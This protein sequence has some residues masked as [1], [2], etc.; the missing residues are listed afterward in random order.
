CRQYDAKQAL[1]MGLINHVVPVDELETET[2]KWCREMLEHSPLALRC[3]KAA[4]NADCD[5]QMGLIDLAGD[6]TLLYYMSDEAKEGRQAY[7][8][9]RKPDFSKFPRLP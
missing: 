2:L 5:G 7:V 6:A 9:K 3:L 1:D 8:E 4:L